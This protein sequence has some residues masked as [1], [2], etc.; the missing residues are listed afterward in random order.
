VT[1]ASGVEKIVAD[2]Y[3]AY[4]SWWLSGLHLVDLDADGD[5]DLFL[6]AHGR[7]PALAALNDG[8]G[9]F[10]EAPGNYPSSEIHLAYDRDEDGK[11]D[12]TMTYQDGGGRWWHNRSV[13]GR[14]DF[15]PTGITRGSICW[16][17]GDTTKRPM[18][19]AACFATTA[20]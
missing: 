17:N 12:L 20:T 5:L 10:A 19:T 8:A 9:N 11:V 16:P 3:A 6:S 13:P 1:G 14:L 15:Q 4:P 7:G 2:H 18:A